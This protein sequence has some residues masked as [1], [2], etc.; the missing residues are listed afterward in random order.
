M[1]ARPLPLDPSRYQY[2]GEH[3]VAPTCRAGVRADGRRGS[4]LLPSPDHPRRGD[5]RA[6]A[7]QERQGALRRRRW[8][9]LARPHVP[10]RGRCRHARHRRVRRG[11]RVQPAAADHPRS[12]RHRP[13]QGGV[14]PRH[15]SG[16]Q[17]PRRGRPARGATRLRQRDADLRRVR[18]DRRRHRQLRHP[19]PGQRRLRAAREAVRL[20]IDLPLRRAGQRLLGRARTLLPLPL[21]RAAAA[22]HGSLCA[23]GGVLGV[24]CASIGS[25]QVNEAIKLLTGTATRSSAG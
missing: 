20:G 21:P 16:D 6:E 3:V 19:L 22:R 23:E 15:G 14:G 13:L 5:D 11:R 18:P 17:S 7:P 12:V 1:A 24:L 10:R 8:P 4:P 2:P 9:R 25:I